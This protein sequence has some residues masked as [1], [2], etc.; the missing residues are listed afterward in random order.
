[1]L[2]LHCIIMLILMVPQIILLNMNHQLWIFYVLVLSN[3]FI[4]PQMLF[5]LLPSICFLEFLKPRDMH[6]LSIILMP[7]LILLMELQT[8]L[9]IFSLFLINGPLPKKFQFLNVSNRICMPQQIQ[10]I[11]KDFQ[12][13]QL[14]CFFSSSSKKISIPP[15]H[16]LLLLV[17]I[18]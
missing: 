8:Q 2:F 9:V 16:I 14:I 15:L 12:I 5:L 6:L 1:M 3:L 7:M 13:L 18:L 11:T 4:I 17:L 10:L